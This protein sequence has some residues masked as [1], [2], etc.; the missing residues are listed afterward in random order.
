MTVER[1]SKLQKEILKYLNAERLR[2][3]RYDRKEYDEIR[4][5]VSEMCDKGIEKKSYLGIDIFISSKS[6]NVVFSQSV[7][8]LHRKGLIELEY[9]YEVPDEYYYYHKKCKGREPFED[10]PCDDCFYI[11]KH[12][13]AELFLVEKKCC[14]RY[15][16]GERGKN[17]IKK[18]VHSIKLTGKG[19]KALKV[20]TTPKKAVDFYP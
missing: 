10:N 17:K 9:K 20:H 4:K 19:R 14:F 11:K 16:T 2:S 7:R 12:P 13:N 3:W 6:F 1:L 8:N 15:F 18:R 5:N